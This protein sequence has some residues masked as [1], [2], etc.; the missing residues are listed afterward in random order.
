MRYYQAEASRTEARD[1]VYEGQGTSTQ[2]GSERSNVVRS[3][4][5]SVVSSIPG[6]GRRLGDSRSSFFGRLRPR[7]T[8]NAQRLR[9]QREKLLSNLE[10]RQAS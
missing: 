1:I 5:P 6:V 8:S 10:Q 3:E 7:Q 2:Y 9:E 4:Q